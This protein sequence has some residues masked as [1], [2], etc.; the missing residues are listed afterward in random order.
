MADHKALPPEIIAMWHAWAAVCEK[1]PAPP[2][3]EHPDY[4]NALFLRRLHAFLGAHTE[5]Q[6]IAT[7]PRDGTPVDLWHRQGF[8]IAEQWWDA[9]DQVWVSDTRSDEDFTHWMP[10]PA[11][12]KDAT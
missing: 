9:E 12:P 3:L 7:A 10:P 8:R 11:P 2:G 5:W 6:P 4:D 1:V